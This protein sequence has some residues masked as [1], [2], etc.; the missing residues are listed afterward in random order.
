MFVGGEGDLRADDDDFVALILIGGGGERW[1]W[2]GETGE[3]VEVGGVYAG[4]AEGVGF[5]DED[6]HG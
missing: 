2:G 6:G 5:F 1:W 4:I 3:G